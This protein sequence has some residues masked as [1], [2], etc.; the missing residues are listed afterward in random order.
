MWT[1][2]SWWDH[3]RDLLYLINQFHDDIVHPIIG[4]GN[5]VGASQL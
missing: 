1:T 4:I 3:G 5:S 2:A